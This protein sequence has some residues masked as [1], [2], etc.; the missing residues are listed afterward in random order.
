MSARLLLAPQ[1]SIELPGTFITGLEHEL[2]TQVVGLIEDMVSAGA[3]D[4]FKL[5]IHPSQRVSHG[6]QP[7]ERVRV[8]KGTSRRVLQRPVILGDDCNRHAYRSMATKDAY[9]LPY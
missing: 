1:R 4:L 2:G 3:L 6:L 7:A 5:T 9:H 8:T